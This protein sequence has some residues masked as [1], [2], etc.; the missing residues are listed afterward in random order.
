MI[1]WLKNPGACPVTEG[2]IVNVRFRDKE[3]GENLPALQYMD[4]LKRDASE[5]F[6]RMDGAIN[7]IIEYQIVG[8]EKARWLD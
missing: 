4:T 6:W 2:T 3:V 7:D 1:E 5:A 8:E